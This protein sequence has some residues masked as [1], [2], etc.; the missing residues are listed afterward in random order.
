M[1][2]IIRILELTACLLCL[3]LRVGAQTLLPDNMEDA[4]CTTEVES[5]DWGVQVHWSSATTVSNFNIP[6][7]G[8]LDGDGHPE[9][10]CFALDGDYSYDPRKN[11]QLLVFDGVTKQQKAQPTE[12]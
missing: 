9:V 12:C 5:M 3:C 2:D 8:D 1:L 10:V 7:V 6:L 11:N 4:E